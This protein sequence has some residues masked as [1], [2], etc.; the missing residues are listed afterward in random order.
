[1]NWQTLRQR[2]QTPTVVREIKE[3]LIVINLEHAALHRYVQPGRTFDLNQPPTHISHP[4]SVTSRLAAALLCGASMLLLSAASPA[5]ALD[6]D[7]AQALAKKSN[8]TKYHSRCA[9]PDRPLSLEF[10]G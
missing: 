2:W 6:A 3:D 7:A 10:V 9:K 8:C 4:M 5:F 1:M